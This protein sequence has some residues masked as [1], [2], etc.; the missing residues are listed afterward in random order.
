MNVR[1]VITHLVLA[2]RNDDSP[3]IEELLK[4]FAHLARFE[5]TLALRTHWQRTWNPTRRRPA[6]GRY[7]RVSGH[8][9][10]HVRWLER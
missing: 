10:R 3:R 5:D 9:A 6:A 7:E 2:V 8:A 4:R 1:E